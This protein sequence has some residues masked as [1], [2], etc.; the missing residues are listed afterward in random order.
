MPRIV[1]VEAG[2]RRH[3]VEAKL[4]ESVMQAATGNLVP[5]IVA[6]CGGSCCCATCHAYVDP[7]WAARMPRIGADEANMLDGVV[8]P[9]PGS[10]LTCQIA[11]TET[12]DG[13]VF[14]LP[15]SQY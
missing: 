11:V 3:E 6:D 1:F 10:R 9:R 2:G 13:A 15:K 5:G 7:P 4:G 12:L 8:E 14:H